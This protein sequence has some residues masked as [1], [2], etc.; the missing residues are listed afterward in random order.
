MNRQINR[1]SLPR[2][3]NLKAVLVVIVLFLLLVN[4]LIFQLGKTHLEW[5][6]ENGVVENI[7]V[8]FLVLASLVFAY[9]YRS[10]HTRSIALCSVVVCLGFILREVD[11]EDF[12]LPAW[13]IFVGSGTGRNIILAVLVVIA[14]ISFVK[15]MNYEKM[16]LLLKS[17]FAV[18]LYMVFC[19]LLCSWLFDKAVFDFAYNLLGEELSE[20]SAYLLILT[21]SII[22]TFEYH[23]R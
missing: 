8:G 2:T 15:E 1:Q 22:Y 17:Y 5:F 4:I 16:L 10:C 19:F 3:V 11:V 6:A 14:M 23:R 12:E 13:V 7:E 21:A 20:S 9:A 18:C